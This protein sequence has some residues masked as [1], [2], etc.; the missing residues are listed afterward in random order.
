MESSGEKL[1]TDEYR[2]QQTLSGSAIG[3]GRD[4][5]AV[6]QRTEQLER[7]LGD[8]KRLADR[9]GGRP[10]FSARAANWQDEH[11][12]PVAPLSSVTR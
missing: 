11:C 6:D 5:L 9:A 10:D 8:P 4:R 2:S 7:P 12:A 1:P 3:S